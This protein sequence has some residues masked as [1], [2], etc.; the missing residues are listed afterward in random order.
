MREGILPS[1]FMPVSFAA[2]LE[3]T[4]LRAAYIIARSPTHKQRTH[5]ET[6]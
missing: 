4:G 3:L 2:F 1:W 6:S 5:K